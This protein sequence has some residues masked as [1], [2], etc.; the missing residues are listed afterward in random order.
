[1]RGCFSAF[2][3]DIELLF[4]ATFGIGTRS[5]WSPSGLGHSLLCPYGYFL[6][7]CCRGGIIRTVLDVMNDED[8]NS[9]HNDRDD[10]E[11]LLGSKVI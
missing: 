3:C 2:G 6:T 10:K 4:L 5:V 11:A 1:M 9:H 8:S 7:A